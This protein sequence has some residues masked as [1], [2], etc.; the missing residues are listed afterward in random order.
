MRNKFP[1]GKSIHSNNITENCPRIN[2]WT[3]SFLETN[4]LKYRDSDGLSQ[5]HHWR[6]AP[7]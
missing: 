3:V 7:L 6:I 4:L 2:S 1:G 5:G